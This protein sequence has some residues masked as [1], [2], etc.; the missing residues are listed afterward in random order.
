MATNQALLALHGNS[1]A[2]VVVAGEDSS[3]LRWLAGAHRHSLGLEARRKTMTPMQMRWY[4]LPFDSS[5]DDDV[6]SSQ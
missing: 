3:W 5:D 1:W 4:R 6:V 2:M